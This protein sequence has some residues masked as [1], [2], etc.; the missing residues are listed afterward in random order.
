M[1][2]KIEFNASLD[3]APKVSSA[4][5][6]ALTKILQQSGGG[7]VA[8]TANS[9]VEAVFDVPAQVYNLSKSYI[10]FTISC[11][12]PG[13]A[14]QTLGAMLDIPPIRRL[15]LYTRS[16]L[17]ICDIQNFQHFW[18]LCSN[19]VTR[20]DDMNSAGSPAYA[21]TLAGALQEGFVNFCQP[22]NAAPATAPA[23][24]DTYH[25]TKINSAVPPAVDNDTTQRRSNQTQAQFV[26]STTNGGALFLNCRL[27]LG[28]VP[29]TIFSCNRDLYTSEAL[30]LR[31]EFEPYDNFMFGHT[32]AATLVGPVSVSTYANA[33]TLTNLAFYLAVEQNQGVRQ[34][35]MDKVMSSGLN[36]T[37]PYVNIYRQVLGTNTSSSVNYKINRGHG[38]RL[39]RVISAE[40]ITADTL[41]SRCNFYNFNAPKTVSFYTTIDS[42]RQQSENLLPNSSL[43][44]K[45]NY[46]KLKGCPLEVAVEYYTQSPVHIDDWSSCDS[47]VQ[48][49]EQDLHIC[50]LPLDQELVWGKVID[51]KT[52]LDTTLNAVIITQ[53]SLLSGA[54]GVVVA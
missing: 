13:Q 48:A 53:K 6:Y 4:P 14:G 21:S 8:I 39:L 45:Y 16:G 31:V 19:L 40:S 20:T 43:D 3:Y 34:S 25:G 10:D 23:S 22:S 30:Q 15:S 49:P 17:Y 29:F 7:S 52:A 37:I 33:P 12:A 35:I 2:S 28:R 50:G 32:A 47:L 38:Q 27:A 26:T 54:Q 51:T 41:T 24:A 42:I 11:A 44:F 5:K 36:L 46:Q 9:S 18:K 1:E